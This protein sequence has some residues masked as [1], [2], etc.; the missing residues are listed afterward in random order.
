MLVLVGRVVFKGI[1]GVN[2]GDGLA[3]EGRGGRIAGNA[4]A[5]VIMVVD[6]GV[7]DE[8]RDIS[9]GGRG[10]VELGKLPL[11]SGLSLPAPRCALA[12]LN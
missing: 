7:R 3:T 12:W 1:I 6:I 4:V 10:P 9:R 5:E 8:D 2:I 11:R